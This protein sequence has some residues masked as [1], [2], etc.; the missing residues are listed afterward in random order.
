MTRETRTAAAATGTRAP[1][2]A[3]WVFST[4]FAEGLPY[5]IIRLMSSAFFT[6]VG[7]KE[8]YLGYLNFLGIPWNLKF[9]WSPLVDLLGTKRAWMIVLQALLSLVTAGV[10]A[11]CLFAPAGPGASP[12]LALV[13]ALFVFLAFLSA[14]NDIAIDGYFQEGI[15]DPGEQALWTGFR[16]FA[17]RVALITARSA[18]IG[19]AAFAAARLAGAGKFA[20]WGYAFGAA[21]LTMGATTLYHLAAAP[22]FEKEGGARRPWA[23]IQRG[24]GRAFITYA[25]QER[26]AVV[27]LFIIFY[28]VGDEILFSMNTPFL[29]RELGVTK[30]QFAW[31]SGILGALGAVAGTILG[32]IWIKRTGLRRA[33]WPLTLLM[34]LNIWAYIWLAWE[35]PAASDPL[36]L[37]TIA[38]VHCYEQIAAGLGSAV[39]TVFIL[40][41]CRPEYKASHFAVGTA[42][43]SLFSTFF[44]GFGG[45]IV[46]RM[47]YLNMFFLAFAASIPSMLLLAFVPV[48]EQAPGPSGNA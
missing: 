12:A 42:I 16:V 14:T 28:K 10:A 8:R 32:G 6:D 47:G 15:V 11:F 18:F 7:L 5:G 40:R 13:V 27:V 3:K 1:S 33:I 48:R 25:R 24:F 29:M 38:A 34:N 43:M 17:Y 36:G 2:P 35:R 26:F 21:A 41:T 44:G 46:E 30:G 20:P 4:Y 19:I 39:L 31:L 37:L 45:L 22:R 9:L 23:D